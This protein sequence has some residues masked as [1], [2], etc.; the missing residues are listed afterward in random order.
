MVA[1]TYTHANVRIYCRPKSKLAN[2][3]SCHPFDE[4]VT[5]VGS[6]YKLST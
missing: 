4:G 2:K 5:Q 6:P 3:P 1:Y